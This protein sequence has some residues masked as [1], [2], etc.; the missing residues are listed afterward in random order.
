MKIKFNLARVREGSDL[1]HT[2]RHLDT[3]LGVWIRLKQIDEISKGRDT[4]TSL[5]PTQKPDCIVLSVPGTANNPGRVPSVS[6]IQGAGNG[7]S[8]KGRQILRALNF[9]KWC[10]FMSSN[11]TGSAQQS[12][13]YTKEWATSPLHPKSP[14][15]RTDSETWTD[16]FILQNSPWLVSL[17]IKIFLQNS[18]LLLKL[19]VPVACCCHL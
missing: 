7:A 12:T 6:W 8:E 3:H 17:P 11:N 14:N 19:L 18:P 1:S 5:G 9:E 16:H 13:G 4:G 15:L 2:Y 10:C